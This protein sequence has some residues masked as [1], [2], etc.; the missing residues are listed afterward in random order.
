MLL[1]RRGARLARELRSEG[2]RALALLERGLGQMADSLSHLAGPA[3]VPDFLPV[4]AYRFTRERLM[5]AGRTPGTGWDVVSARDSLRASTSTLLSTAE[6]TG[7][8]TPGATD[9]NP[10]PPA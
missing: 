10:R 9:S 7:C 5:S 4:L 3:Q 6:R 8:F 1:G 2:E